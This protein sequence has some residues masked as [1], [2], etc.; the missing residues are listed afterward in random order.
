VATNYITIRQTQQQIELAEANVKLQSEVLTIVRA[1]F[2]NGA[3]SELD[4]DQAEATLQQTKATI[5]AFQITLRQ[6]ENALCTLLAI[7]PVD[8]EARLG[9]SPIP[10]APPEA[11]VGI[12]ANLLER[13]PDIRRAERQA[14][15]QAEQIGIAMTDWYPH[16]SIDGNVGVTARNFSQL[17]TPAAF[18]GNIGPTFSWDV[19]NYGR[20]ANNVHLQDAKF[21]E[22]LLDYRSTV[23]NANQ[24]AENGLITY[25]KAHDEARELRASVI[26]ANRAAIIVVA[27]YRVGTVDF[28]T[29]SQ[30][31]QNLVTE[32]NLYAQSLGQICQ[33]LI[34]VYRALGGGWELRLG[35]DYR[36]PCPPPVMA[37]PPAE[38][39][40]IPVLNLNAPPGAQPIPA[41]PGRPVPRH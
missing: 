12:P 22:L 34:T 19:L 7:P 25:L 38:I 39:P 24:E 40:P 8:L 1:R 16:I 15:A 3:T 27:Q 13:R 10:G 2:Q 32:Q 30:I 33:G 14:A 28:T 20:I 23:L 35:P 36:S 41:P 11:V 29:V 6:S 18:N 21:Q 17:A 37:P 5:P 31:E 26:A 4:V 9:R